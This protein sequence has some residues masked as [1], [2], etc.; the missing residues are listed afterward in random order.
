MAVR[1]ALLARG[2]S[3]AANALVTV[4]TCP[5]GKTA[6]VKDVRMLSAGDPVTNAIV[7]LTSG[8]ALMHV[9]DGPLVVGD[10]VVAQGFIVLEPGDQIKVVC[11]GANS[12]FFWISGAELSGVAP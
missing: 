10:P 1:T 3:G 7:R 8:S 11:T 2:Q 9:I 6:I 4:Y 5:A 12:A